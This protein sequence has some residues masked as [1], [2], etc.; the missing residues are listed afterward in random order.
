MWK[1]QKGVKFLSQHGHR[2]GTFGCTAGDFDLAI[3]CPV[4]ASEALIEV[5]A[6]GS[7]GICGGELI[8]TLDPRVP[9]CDIHC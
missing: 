6:F 1:Q 8:C 5:E 2:P 9:F 7:G 3:E 4:K